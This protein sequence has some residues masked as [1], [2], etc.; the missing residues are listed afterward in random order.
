MTEPNATDKSDQLIDPPYGWARV[1]GLGKPTN[2]FHLDPSRPD[3]PEKWRS[4]AEQR[5]RDRL[6]RDPG[7][8]AEVERLRVEFGRYLPAIDSEKIVR[9]TE[10]RRHGGDA[11]LERYAEIALEH[12]EMQIRHAV[13]RSIPEGVSPSIAFQYIGE[14]TL[15]IDLVFALSNELPAPLTIIVNQ[16]TGKLL[17]AAMPGEAVIRFRGIIRRD[18]NRIGKFITEAIA[19]Q[20]P[21]RDVY[22]QGGRRAIDEEPDSIATAELVARLFH[23]EGWSQRSIAAFLGWLKP[24]DE[25]D[26]PKTRARIEQR[27]RR[28]LRI[29]ENELKKN[30]EGES[31]KQRPAQ[32]DAARQA[33]DRKKGRR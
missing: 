8:R 3:Y 30:A 4:R 6:S 33:E 19:I 32:L 14:Q 11:N 29:G 31:W 23:W 20:S 2:V 13:E 26:D 5:D 10:I 9:A 16:H 1:D 24:T 21:D 25:W 17:M 18:I 15:P 27:V 7:V 28:W 12:F 22:N